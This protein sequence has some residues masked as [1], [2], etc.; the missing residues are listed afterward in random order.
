MHGPGAQSEILVINADKCRYFTSHPTANIPFAAN[1]SSIAQC[2][3]TG[4][5][6]LSCSFILAMGKV[7]MFPCARLSD[8]FFWC[9]LL[10]QFWFQSILPVPR[11][12]EN[13]RRSPHF[14]WPHS[15]HLRH[16]WMGRSAGPQGCK[17]CF[18]TLENNPKPP[19]SSPSP[20]P[21]VIW[22]TVR[23]TFH[24]LLPP[25]PNCFLYTPGKV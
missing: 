20:L 5:A 22:S 9:T 21:F 3:S 18:T 11:I 7:G 15:K 6:P 8:F 25:C 10:V 12:V 14:F 1:W 19:R 16:D 13:S 17:T 24:K 4:L 23:L 2:A